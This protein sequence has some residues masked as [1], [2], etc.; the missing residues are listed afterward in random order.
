[1]I[2]LTQ[3]SA[4]LLLYMNDATYL[5]PYTQNDEMLSTVKDFLTNAH[6]W[7][8]VNWQK[9]SSSQTKFSILT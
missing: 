3:N 6:K 8:L 5:K 2:Y 9:L 1:M 4:K 7:F